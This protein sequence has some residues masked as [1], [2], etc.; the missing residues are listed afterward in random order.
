MRRALNR[1]FLILSLASAGAMLCGAVI[2]AFGYLMPFE[3]WVSCFSAYAL[4]FFVAFRL[5]L[6]KPTNQIMTDC[7]HS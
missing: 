6:P 1:L 2:E 5:T 3:G 4:I 7:N